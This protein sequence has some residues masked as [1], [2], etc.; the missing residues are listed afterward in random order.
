MDTSP[1][2]YFKEYNFAESLV[3]RIDSQPEL[4]QLEIILNYMGFV[5]TIARPLDDPTLQD[6]TDFRRLVFSDVTQLARTDYR[7][8]VG[9][10]DFD[11]TN[12]N[13]S[14]T[15]SISPVLVE[16][17]EVR[18]IVDARRTV[19]RY[20]ARAYMGSVGTYGFE[21]GSLSVDQR[22]VKTVPLSGCESMHFDYHTGQRIDYLNPF[23]EKEK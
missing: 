20:T 12:F 7:F 4:G 19:A 11:P 2:T 21:F 13:L 22:L 8:N 9:F 5:R 15:D 23:S 10:L 14:E 17:A 16:A 6:P 1:T 3:Q 18:K